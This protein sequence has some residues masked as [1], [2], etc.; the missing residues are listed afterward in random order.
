LRWLAIRLCGAISARNGAV[1]T[2]VEIRP[3]AG[4]AIGA[5]DSAIGR[6][7]RNVPQSEQ[8]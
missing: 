4:Q 5:S 8:L 1:T 6:I 3:H 7:L 2:F